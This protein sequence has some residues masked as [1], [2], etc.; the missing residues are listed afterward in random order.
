M[1]NE[2]LLYIKNVHCIKVCVVKAHISAETQKRNHSTWVRLNEK[3]FMKNILE[4]RIRCIEVWEQSGLRKTTLKGWYSSVWT[5][6]LKLAD[7][8]G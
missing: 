1:L 4:V 8:K 6:G 5:D 7:L 2:G 3:I